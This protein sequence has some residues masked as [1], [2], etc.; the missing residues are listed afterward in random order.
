M[1]G[2]IG[3][4][5]LETDALFNAME[6]PQ[7]FSVGWSRFAVGKLYGLDCVIAQCGIGKVHAAAC[8]Q[9]M[10]MKWLV[11]AVINFGV[12]GALDETL[13]ISD[14]V[15]ADFSAQHDIDTSPIGDPVGLI[16]GPNIIRIPCDTALTD[17]LKRSADQCGIR[18]ISRSIVTGDQ[19]IDRFED[20]KRIRDLFEA[21]ACD[22]EGG[23]IAQICW[24]SHVPYAACRTIS[25]TMTGSGREYAECAA[26][27]G[28]E[29][30][31]LLKTALI[32]Y[33]EEKKQ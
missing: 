12:A 13:H 26:E 19:F 5:A 9:V 23:A 10:L 28:A 1:L 27:A 7:L 2:L 21:G 33:R 3:A 6:D 17:L 18:R 11:D 30:C 24:E 31:R 4:M 29:C 16:S 22:M 32:N 8:A 20:K 25:D 15:I 14:A